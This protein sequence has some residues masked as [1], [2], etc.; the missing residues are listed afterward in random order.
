MEIYL[1]AI[2]DVIIVIAPIIVAYISYRGNK[3]TQNDIRLEA[4]RIAKEK[5]AETK[6]ILDKIGAE[7]ESQKQLMTWQNSIPQTNEYTNLA[8]TKRFGN[9]SAL[10]KLTQDIF[11][12]FE[13]RSFD[14]IADRT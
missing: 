14:R 12:F 13:F 2:K 11:S 4:E 6:Q 9:I 3:K 1:T 5:E 7:L 8:E 10:P